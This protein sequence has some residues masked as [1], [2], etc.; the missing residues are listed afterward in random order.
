M[1]TASDRSQPQACRPP[2]QSPAFTDHSPE[3]AYR[4]EQSVASCAERPDLGP[5][6]ERRD[7]TR[8]GADVRAEPV[9]SCFGHGDREMIAIGCIRRGKLATQGDQVDDSDTGSGLVLLDCCQA[10][11][12]SATIHDLAY[13]TLPR[14]AVVETI[15]RDPLP[16]GSAPTPLPRNGLSRILLAQ[17]DALAEH[18]ESLDEAETAAAL[19]GATAV[20]FA[21]LAKL[22]GTP[23]E[24]Q[25]SGEDGFYASARRHIELN[26]W[27]HDLTAAGI[28]AAVG[29]SRAHLYRMFG[30]RGQTVAGCLRDVRLMRARSQLESEPLQSIGTIAFD[31]GYSDLSA[32][33]KA[34]KRRFGTTPR[35]WR[36]RAAAREF[37]DQ[38]NDQMVH[39]PDGRTHTV[40]I[41]GCAA[42]TPS[43]DGHTPRATPKSIEPRQSDRTVAEI[44]AAHDGRYTV[45]LHLKQDARATEDYAETPARRLK[46]VRRDT[47]AVSRLPNGTWIIDS[48]TV[49]FRLPGKDS[50][51]LGRAIP[52][53][54]PR[55]EVS[56]R[57][58]LQI[59]RT[60]VASMFS[61]PQRPTKWS[62]E[63]IRCDGGALGRSG[64]PTKSPSSS[65][66][67]SAK[68]S[69]LLTPLPLAVPPCGS[70]ARASAC[71][72]RAAMAFATCRSQVRNSL[73]SV[74]GSAS[75]RC[76]MPSLT[77]S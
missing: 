19:Q 23:P 12:C 69:W 38:R 4:R 75:C 40:G 29:C 48:Q 10:A 16:A 71:C 2:L 74:I 13:L 5:E 55:L 46:T 53:L 6:S 50:P 44:A 66:T 58:S 39:W 9:V 76:V 21:L 64:R 63:A 43:P 42:A 11:T 61:V 36:Q 30:A 24:Q 25:P 73:P 26:A 33:G 8:G 45:D 70:S 41:G 54:P 27:R 18:G 35:D 7:E 37:S 15:G 47:G 17:L 62:C 59:L 67:F 72:C 49:A 32:F 51:S 20:A 65:A 31:A 52:G 56:S 68:P 3:K 34:F 77:W 1:K 60:A 28:A 22:F 14:S 57:M